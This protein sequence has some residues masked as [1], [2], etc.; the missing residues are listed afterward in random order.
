MGWRSAPFSSKLAG[1]PGESPQ[2]P[3]SLGATLVIAFV[4]FLVLAF[5]VR[6]YT[7]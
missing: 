6:W 3:A 1:A 5:L 2:K 4:I 7:S